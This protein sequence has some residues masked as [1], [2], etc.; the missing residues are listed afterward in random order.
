[1]EDLGLTEKDVPNSIAHSKADD[2]HGKMFLPFLEQHVPVGEEEKVLEAA[3]ESLE[4][5]AVWYEGMTT[6]VEKID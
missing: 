6:V 4:L 2:K 5:R 1:M 3:K